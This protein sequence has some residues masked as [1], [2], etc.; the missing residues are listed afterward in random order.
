MIYSGKNGDRPAYLARLAVTALLDEVELTPKPALVDERGSGAHTDLSLE[1]MKRSARHLRPHFENIAVAS[2]LKEP[3]KEL[4][5]ELGALGRAA[6]SSMLSVTG[7]INTHRGAIW[8]LGLLVSAA[9]MGSSVPAE[10]ASRA[11]Q[12][13]RFSDCNA[14][15]QE[16]HGSI[17]SR[18]YKVSGAR[19]EG[20]EGF[21][22]VVNIGLPALRRSRRHSDRETEAR[23]D[24]LM[25]IMMSLDDTCLL[26]RGGLLG[27]RT[28]QSGAAAV[29]RAG[30]SATIWGGGRLEQ[31]DRDLKSLN[32]SPGGSADLLAATLFLDLI[33]NA[34]EALHGVFVTDPNGRIAFKQHSLSCCIEFPPVEGSVSVDNDL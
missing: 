25:A 20:C 3:C 31:L 9:A 22:H 8:T 15:G 10:V 33:S 14:P 13:A 28:A 26:Y 6:E 4:R 24:A 32:C 29:L 5:E 12:L 18:H 34:K 1:L 21:P 17:V 11:G 23:L 2:F 16:T 19:G 30:G 7:G 27:L